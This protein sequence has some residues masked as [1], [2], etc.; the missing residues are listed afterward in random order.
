MT[1]KFSYDSDVSISKKAM[2]YLGL[3]LPDRS[4]A[5]EFPLTPS[6]KYAAKPETSVET[7]NSVFYKISSKPFEVLDKIRKDLIQTNAYPIDSTQRLALSQAYWHNLYLMSTKLIKKFQSHG[8]VPDGKQRS[9]LLDLTFEALDHVRRS[10]QLVF[11]HDYDLPNRH[12]GRNRKRIYEA[13]FCT[14]EIIQLEQTIGALRYRSLTPA[15]WQT[16][17]KIF[18]VML[19]YE[20]VS[21]KQLLTRCKIKSGVPAVYESIEQIYIRVQ[22]LGYFNLLRYPTEQQNI[23]STYICTHAKTMSVNT[24]DQAA[25]LESNALVMGHNQNK[26]PC[27]QCETNSKQSPGCMINIKALKSDLQKISIA[28]DTEE[29]TPQHIMA[30]AEKFEYIPQKDRLS[31][32]KTLNAR[33]L[34]NKNQDFNF[35]SGKAV[36]LAIDSG[37]NQCYELKLD[38]KRSAAQRFSLRNQQ[39]ASANQPAGDTAEVQSLW[40]CLYS[41]KNTMILQTQETNYTVQMSL[42]G[43]VAYANRGSVDKQHTFAS[44][45]KLERLERGQINIELS[46]I[47]DHAEAVSI[48]TQHSDANALKNKKHPALLITQ[49]GQWQII[50]PS[51]CVNR[52]LHEITMS[53]DKDSFQLSLGKC[54]TATQALSVFEL[55]GKQIDALNP[56]FTKISHKKQL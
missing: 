49:D 21:A 46:I 5:L 43:I 12:Y 48:S 39:A 23:L 25:L 11:L 35:S 45:S 17:N 1:S 55:R 4:L 8:S 14:M 52:S 18:H 3:G 41:D 19:A 34:W 56:L 16:L 53:R 10:Y 50:I 47:A 32:F 13:A 27:V 7:I 22:L 42:G 6:S 28:L 36:N 40:Y 38:D 37:F 33:V 44:I 24:L 31:L 2:R 9:Q 20:K 15:S 30:N 54:I 29:D 51:H 26:A